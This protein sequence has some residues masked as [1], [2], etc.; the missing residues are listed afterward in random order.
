VSF[1]TVLICLFAAFY[2]MLWSFWVEELLIEM[3]HNNG[4][5]VASI[6]VFLPSVVYAVLVYVMNLYYRK[7]A[8]YLTEWGKYYFVNC[9]TRLYHKS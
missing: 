9:S 3:Q 2:I 8:G 6:L 7:L 4:S 5:Q 1:P